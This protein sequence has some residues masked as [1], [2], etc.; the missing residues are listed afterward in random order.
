MRQQIWGILDDLSDTPVWKNIGPL[1]IGFRKQFNEILITIVEKG[2]KSD[3]KDLNW[4]RWVMKSDRFKIKLSPVFP[5]KPIIVRTEHPFR[6]T[7]NAKARVYTL[8]PVWVRIT[9]IDNPDNVIMEIPVQTLSKTWFGDPVDGELC[10][11]I[12]TTARRQLQKDSIDGYQAICSLNIQNRSESDL[13]VEKICFRVE[14]L[15]LFQKDME[16]WADDTEITYR[17]SEQHSDIIMTGR[18]PKEITGAHKVGEPRNV[19]K[20]S[21]AIRTFQRIRE[22]PLFGE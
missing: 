16:L 20:K 12:S 7:K 6:I 14:R 1:K 3:D 13:Q 17:G 10:Y 5:D 15:T 8:I 11:W 4:S 21:M 2:S 19:T 22:I 18:V 9:A